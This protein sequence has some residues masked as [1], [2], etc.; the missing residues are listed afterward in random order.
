MGLRGRAKKVSTLLAQVLPLFEVRRRRRCGPKFTG[1]LNPPPTSP[2]GQIYFC[3]APIVRG[4]DR[5]GNGE[6]AQKLALEKRES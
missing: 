5:G 2:R 3:R 6:E 4:R 1:N